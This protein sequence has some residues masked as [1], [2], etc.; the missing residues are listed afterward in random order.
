MKRACLGILCAGFAVLVLTAVTQAA[1]IT[2]IHDD[3]FDP[4]TQDYETYFT[5]YGYGALAGY[6]L[7]WDP[8]TSHFAPNDPNWRPAAAPQYGQNPPD[9]DFKTIGGGGGGGGGGSGTNASLQTFTLGNKKGGAWS[10]DFSILLFDPLFSGTEVNVY[11]IGEDPN[12]PTNAQNA[13]F[14]QAV[15]Q[16]GRIVTFNIDGAAGELVTVYIE[17]MGAASYAAGFFMNDGNFAAVVPEPMTLGLLAMG[18]AGLVA[19]RR[20]R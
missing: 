5:N 4:R 2:P 18:A 1:L 3:P 17:A 16:A 7:T 14:G 13:T 20:R 15:V 19:A 9:L 10:M 11:L 12:D 8:A 6:Q